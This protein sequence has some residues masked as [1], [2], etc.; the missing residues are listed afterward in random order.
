MGWW[1]VLGEISWGEGR[2]RTSNLEAQ[3]REK[4]AMEG[5]QRGHDDL[6]PVKL[7]WSLALRC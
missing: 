1:M 7:M 6:M 4:S 3:Q 2:K 5:C